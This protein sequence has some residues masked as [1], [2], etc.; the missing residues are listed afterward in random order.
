MVDGGPEALEEH[1]L[2]VSSSAPALRWSTLWNLHRQ[3]GAGHC[4]SLRVAP[5]W[6]I[7]SSEHGAGGRGY[8][9]NHFAPLMP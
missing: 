4:Q 2:G 9:G 5:R 7:L 1:L 8:A 6:S 3:N